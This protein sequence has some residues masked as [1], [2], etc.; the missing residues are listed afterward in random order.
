MTG[1]GL[2]AALFVA[3]GKALSRSLLMRPPLNLAAA[4]ANISAELSH[5]NG[6]MMALSLV[7]GVLDIT[8][9]RLDLCNAGFENP[10]LVDAAGVVRE[11]KLEG[12]PAL[13]VVDGYRYPVETH[14]LAPGETLIV[15]SDGVTEAQD[16]EGDLFSREAAMLLLAGGSARPLAGLIESLVAAVRAFEAGE[17]ASDDLTV[18]AL[19]R[20]ASLSA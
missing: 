13:C 10:L 1:K 17:E 16:P 7:V 15:Y 4:L 9:G 18:L 19:R 5:D 11:L 20:P 12:G 8:S 6:E 3:L 2:A 14:S